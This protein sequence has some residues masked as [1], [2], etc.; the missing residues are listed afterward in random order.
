MKFAALGDLGREESLLVAVTLSAPLGL[1]TEG[2][3]VGRGKDSHRTP[4]APEGAPARN[5]HDIP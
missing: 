3:R 2:F 4:P 1:R 5:V